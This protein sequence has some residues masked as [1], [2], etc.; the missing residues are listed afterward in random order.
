RAMVTIAV[1]RRHE[2]SATL[3][4]RTTSDRALL[5]S[6]LERDR[7]W[8]AYAICDLDDREFKRTRW[9]GAFA[10]SDLVAVALEYA[11]TTPQPLFLMGRP[12][13]LEMILRDVIR[14]RAAYVAAMPD[15][16]PVVARHYR[17]DPGPQMVRMWVD[18]TT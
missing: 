18:R 6:F 10:G 5:R 12:D 14:P 3:V 2:A 4:A 1:N 13:G 16:L 9:A 11:G 15:V 17:I 7:L 8:A